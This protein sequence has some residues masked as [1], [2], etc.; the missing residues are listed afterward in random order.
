MVFRL[1]AYGILC[2]SMGITLA[3]SILILKLYIMEIKH[4]RRN[5][6][7]LEETEE[8]SGD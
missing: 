1:L 2:V 8:S 7:K 4:E 5:H 6:K 3:G